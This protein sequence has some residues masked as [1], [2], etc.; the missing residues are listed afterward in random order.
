MRCA[1]RLCTSR[2]NSILAAALAACVLCG[3]FTSEVRAW[4]ARRQPTTDKRQTGKAVGG[5]R[6]SAPTG[7]PAPEQGLD[8]RVDAALSVRPLSPRTLV[9][10]L[11]QAVAAREVAL[12]G[13]IA[14]A[15]EHEASPSIDQLIAA[16][17]ALGSDHPATRRLW[18]RAWQGVGRKGLFA[19]VIAEGLADTLLASG[20]ADEAHTVVVEAL[21]R[22]RAGQRRG[23]YDRLAAIARLRHEVA[24]TATDLAGRKDPDAL[25]VAAALHSE[26]G[27]D[28]AALE[29]LDR[30]WRGYPGHR[31]V[32]GALVQL[33]V[34]LGRREELR[35]VLDQVV[36]LAPAD[37]MPYVA[38]L[39][40]HI[41]ARDAYSARKLIDELAGRYPRHD[42][43][44]EALVDREQRLGDEGARIRKLY[45][46]LLA[47]APQ[48]IPY[49]EAFAEWLLSRGRSEEAMDLLAKSAGRG[50]SAQSELRQAQVLIGHRMAKA[51]RGVVDKL[52]ARL[53]DDPQV[54]RLQAQLAELEGRSRVA[55]QH[56]LQLTRLGSDPSPADRKRA[57]D[58]RQAY[59]A[60]L[61]REHALAARRTALQREVTAGEPEL[62]SA[63]VFMDVAAHDEDETLPDG[64]AWTA[65]AEA[66]LR[67]WPMDAEVL[68]MVATGLLRR[69]R[70]DAATEAALRLQAR[71]PDAAEPLL[72]Q[73]LD[74]AL[75][76]GQSSVASSIEAAMLNRGGTPSVSSL[77]RLGDLHLRYG[78]ATG[79]VELYR[80]AA[81]QRADTRAT[82]RLAALYRQTGEPALEES[83]LRD[84]VQ[85][86]LDPDELDTAGQ[87]LVTVALVRGQTAE[88]VRWLDAIAPQHARRDAVARLRSAAYDTW[89][90]AQAALDQAA[91]RTAPSPG[92][93]GE[94]LG[95][96]DLGQQIRALRHHAAARR[97]L[98]A[99]QARQLVQ[100]SNPAIRRDVALA[101]GAVGTAAATEILRDILFEGM[102]PDEEVRVAQLLAL[103]NLPAVTGLDPVLDRVH[104]RADR[105]LE[106]LLVGVH[107]SP[108][109][110]QALLAAHGRDGR[111]T[112]LA[113]L[114]AMGAMA[115]RNRTAP[116]TDALLRVLLQEVAQLDTAPPDVARALC[117]LWALRASGHSGCSELLLRIAVATPNLTVRAA[118]LNLLATA[119]AP[120]LALPLPQI[121]QHDDVR[122]LKAA[123]MQRT[124]SPW[125]RQDPAAVAR[126]LTTHAAGLSAQIE[127]M[128]AGR[129]SERQAVTQFCADIASVV[130]QLPACAQHESPPVAP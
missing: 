19:G 30:A 37:P 118:A 110:H 29:T 55:E 83:A 61:R 111:D 49:A 27:G 80:R 16:A 20:K 48:Q 104:S 103:A 40:A 94:A 63:L 86:S 32:Q 64:A 102:D 33:L 28:E 126:V 87:R 53:S 98:P 62:A 39:D 89:L 100:S 106:V 92:A 2:R 67:R 4:S 115:G 1:L 59:V 109:L 14:S 123:S 22:A 51:A 66:C 99:A 17:Q 116:E 120:A 96:G 105:S 54:I 93:L 77:L 113:A 18:Q 95:S 79:A 108:A 5:E 35:T 56:W 57:A 107:G 74:H 58:A 12:V 41:A 21:G 23:L 11:R 15:L 52:A 7:S 65:V 44:L 84:I 26:S 82:A 75:A 38:L 9:P 128:R 127:R 85:R 71:E 69:D 36:R 6:R 129:P 97:L 3:A 122:E 114:L 45:E 130:P 10:L 60:L 73:L 25:V 70:V 121:G 68:M 43:L 125:A 101:L 42:I 31:A 90:R 88:L 119:T 117:A 47:A 91:G 81:A 24:E 8:A 76:R 50:N 46:R 112:S 13:R 124:L 78:D 34:R 72:Q